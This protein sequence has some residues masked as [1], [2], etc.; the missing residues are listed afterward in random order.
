MMRA[1]F[2]DG[3]PIG[4]R[5]ALVRIAADAGLDAEEARALLAGDRFTDEVRADEARA[6]EL[7]IT[8]VPFFVFAEKYA[9]SGAQPLEVLIQALMRAA[10]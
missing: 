5:D 9:V 8:G 10:T 3:E 6:Q 2:T 7:G 4:D 1:Y